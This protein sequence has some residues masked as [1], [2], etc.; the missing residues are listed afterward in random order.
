MFAQYKPSFAAPLE[1]QT[2]EKASFRSPYSVCQA[3][4][5]VEIG[6]VPCEVYQ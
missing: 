4:K 3:L 5:V 1:Y 2:V 6:A